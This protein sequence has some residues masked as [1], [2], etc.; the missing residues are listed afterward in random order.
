[1]YSKVNVGDLFIIPFQDKY[2][3]G[4]ILHISKRTRKVFSFILYNKIY[5]NKNIN[6]NKL[7]E[8]MV[9]IKLYTG[10]TKVFYTSVEIFKDKNWEIIG[11]KILNEIENTDLQYHNIGGK[12]YK[13]DEYIRA[14]TEEELESELY[15]K[16]LIAGYEAIEIY[17]KIIFDKK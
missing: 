2:I 1:M 9:E 16:R 4:K 17:L 7:N 13:G 14:L 3:M 15:P 11:N 10:L 8:T 6:L 12:L 5:D